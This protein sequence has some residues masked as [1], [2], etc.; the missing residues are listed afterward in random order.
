M[1]FQW[2]LSDSK[3]PQFTGTVLS[4]LRDLQGCGF[5]NIYSYSDFQHI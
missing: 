1:V 4:I 2:S 3:S 5:Y